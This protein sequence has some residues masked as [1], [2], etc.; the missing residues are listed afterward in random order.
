[1][2]F[3]GGFKDS[4]NKRA[5]DLRSGD[6]FEDVSKNP[7]KLRRILNLWLTPTFKPTFIPE[8]AQEEAEYELLGPSLDEKRHVPRRM[9]DIGTGN[10]VDW[11][12]DDVGHYCM[13]SHQWKGTEVTYDYVKKAR[14]HNS[15]NVKAGKPDAKNDVDMIYKLCEQEIL[16]SEQ[17]IRELLGQVPGRQGDDVEK[18]LA[19]RI[20]VNSIKWRQK[21]ATKQL[22]DAKAQLENTDLESDAFM[23]LALEMESTVAL[24][25]STSKQ[26]SEPARSSP[27]PSAADLEKA[28]TAVDQAQINLNNV[29][30]ETS[31]PEKEQMIKFF[32]E[33]GLIRDAVDELLDL[34]QRW[35]SVIKI[36][37]SLEH[38]KEIFDSKLFPTSERRYLW[39]D[40]CCINKADANELVN[41]L[42]LMGDWYA[43]ADFCLVHLDTRRPQD[44]WIEEW[45][46]F[47]RRTGTEP[48]LPKPNYKSFHNIRDDPPEWS[49]RGWTL[50]ELVLSKM[51]FY[52]NSAWEPL[53]RPVE[54]L[55]PYYFFCPFIELYVPKSATVDREEIKAAQNLILIL[56]ALG[57]HIPGSI[58]RE[59]AIPCISQAVYL[60][61]TGM[62]K[63]VKAADSSK[64]L[65]THNLSVRLEQDVEKVFP[66]RNMGGRPE[67][68]ARRMIKFLLR[69]L[70]AETR[71]LIRSDREDIAKFGKIDALESWQD[72]TERSKFPTQKVMNLAAHRV[73]TVEIDRAY[74]LMGLLGVRFP[75]FAAEGLPKALVRL[76]DEVLTISNDVSVF[77]WAGTDMGSH[78]RGRS[79]YPSSLKA[80]H[81]D[82]GDGQ[83][84]ALKRLAELLDTKRSGVMQTF[85]HVV[86]MLHMTITFLKKHDHKLI[87][88]DWIT[89]IINF[90]HS[91]DFEVLEPQLQHIEGIIAW[92]T[93]KCGRALDNE[94][95]H[96]A[97]QKSGLRQCDSIADVAKNPMGSILGPS[98]KTSYSNKWGPSAR[99]IKTEDGTP[100]SPTPSSASTAVDDENYDIPSL[101]EDVRRLNGPVMTWLNDS[102]AT[103]SSGVVAGPGSDVVARL[104]KEILDG[105]AQLNRPDVEANRERQAKMQ[106]K[107][108]MI[109][110]NPII[111]TNSGIE[112]V[113]DIQRVI[114][115][116]AEEEKLWNQV[117]NAA[118][119]HQK[120]TGWCSI[121]TGF[122]RVMVSFSCEKQVLEKQL[123]IAQVIKRKVLSEPSRRKDELDAKTKSVEEAGQGDGNELGQT[124][125]DEKKVTR[126]IAFI[127]EENLDA[128][129][130]EW[131]LARFSDVE[132]AQWFL[133]SLELGSMHSFNGH[134]IPTGKIDFNDAIPEPGLLNV[135]QTYMM[136]KKR[137][138]CNVLLDYLSSRTMGAARDVIL[139]NGH[140]HDESESLLSHALELGKSV[141]Q[142]AA[143]VAALSLMEGVYEMKANYLDRTLTAA[144]LKYTP[145]ELQPAVE[146]L[147]ADKDFRPAMF[148][149]GRRIHMF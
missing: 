65:L 91:A 29:T 127:E 87:P 135:W 120:I 77:N 114:I 56:D 20:E 64:L 101:E 78:I 10:M 112:G 79:L 145:K 70:V 18:L 108:E 38:S 55:G 23:T 57:L 102:L 85:Q 118:S 144:V 110:P 81:T 148:H 22:R 39:N 103:L 121:S 24:G 63:E 117:K 73:C 58:E 88:I 13:L 72:G 43:N 100:E 19:E 140:E 69:C 111:V 21:A 51:T 26:K 116:F 53:G 47:K 90:I 105:H 8:K 115:I 34:L 119:P 11:D 139:K 82:G 130:G 75:T 74:S 128:V 96:P 61:A 7:E 54:N 133:C 84:V 123:M 46:R 12:S 2:N 48:E 68:D 131:V 36:K 32:H 146:N 138:L 142:N 143:G 134:R 9:F 107:T 106:G 17:T 80:F 1:M 25:P 147:N 28:Q 37:K 129:S 66:A 92:V 14:K 95:K 42:S 40:T 137:K 132:G 3:V 59:T 6:T 98:R 4:L 109:S 35:K 52:V 125:K 16:E 97:G 76:F 45:D 86:T 60:A 113:F 31:T 99:R 41:S 71:D 62:R 33:E 126:M 136:R 50:Q 49:T 93:K 104:P 27:N 89:K 94:D 122:A 149:S 141:V 30:Q 15:E 83:S 124:T 67:G 5:T 44:D